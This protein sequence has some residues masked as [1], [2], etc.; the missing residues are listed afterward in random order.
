MFISLLALISNFIVFLFLIIA[1]PSDMET[2]L[3]SLAFLNVFSVN[4]PLLFATVF[5]FSTS[6]RQERP[7]IKYFRRR[8]AREVF[9]LGSTF[10]L[11]QVLGLVINWTNEML[12]SLLADTQYVVTY[13]AYNRLFL[14]G[15]TLFAL[16]LTPLWS[17][18][19][20]ALAEQ[21]FSW[22][23]K[24]YKLLVVLSLLACVAEIALLPLAQFLFDFW[25]GKGA[26]TVNWDIAVSF[27]LLCCVSIWVDSFNAVNR[28]MGKL[29][30]QI[31]LLMFA[32]L[33]K[34]P[35]A[36]VLYHLL[37]SWS[38]VVLANVILYIPLCIG[39]PI[40]VRRDILKAERDARN[41]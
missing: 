40:I 27:V 5:V 33:L 22:M 10:F 1:T 31:I 9:Q 6:L 7:S 35:L 18:V 20:K 3:L 32:A 39:M 29:K 37:A 17:A 34:I 12:I 23:K 15:F 38:A 28:G 19:T 30:P 13:Q 4:L 24:Q 21:R 41:Q 16:V 2:N 14:L 25:L 11:I 8:Y 36:I 26:I